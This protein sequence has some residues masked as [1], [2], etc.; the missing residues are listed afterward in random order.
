MPTNAGIKAKKH[1]KGP[2][3]NKIIAE[4]NEEDERTLS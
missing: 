4:N 3:L 1:M 2:K